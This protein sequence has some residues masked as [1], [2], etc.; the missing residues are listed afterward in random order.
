MILVDTTS[1]CYSVPLYLTV[2]YGILALPLNS[3][4]VAIFDEYGLRKLEQVSSSSVY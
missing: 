3:A 4:T 1:Y 2:V